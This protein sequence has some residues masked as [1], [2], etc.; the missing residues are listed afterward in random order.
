[1]SN[2]GLEKRLTAFIFRPVVV[3]SSC[4]SLS[5][6]YLFSSASLSLR[7]KK[8]ETRVLL[9]LSF[10]EKE[11]GTARLGY[12]LEWK[13]LKRSAHVKNRPPLSHVA[14]FRYWSLSSVSEQLF[15]EVGSLSLTVLSSVPLREILF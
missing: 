13:C 10:A 5:I 1:M 4:V 15:A 11:R 14:R 9:S 6:C 12:I 2:S 3:A 7:K 8:V